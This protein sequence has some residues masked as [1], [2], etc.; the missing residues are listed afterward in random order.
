M[1]SIEQSVQLD[2]VGEHEYSA[3]LTPDWALWS[4]AGGFLTSLMMNA[5]G[6][7]TDFPQPI[8]FGCQF[9]RR[10][11]FNTVTLRVQSLR[12]GRRTEALRVDMFQAK[13]LI[14]TAQVWV[15][16]GA[17]DG[18]QHDDTGPQ[19]LPDPEA[20]PKYA[21]IYPDDPM[22]PFFDRFD[23]RP[24]DP[25][26]RGDETAHP[27]VLRGFY[28][29]LPAI[30]PDN[31]FVDAARAMVLIDTFSWLATYPAHPGDGPSPWIAPNLDFYYRF[32][33]ASLGDAW[34]FMENRADLAEG[35]LIAVAGDIR[36]QNG[37]LLVRGASQL[38]CLPRPV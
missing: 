7:E 36:N 27:A 22:P 26:L 21:E 29:F 11:T 12:R 35:G 2:K 24:I 8:S 38:I 4:P 5:A 19:E 6:L 15:G 30:L 34:L 20:L 1:K 14:A 10:A 13:D 25:V 3:Q 23:H 17:S 28:R 9:L 31:A 37:D 18:M 32:H 16:Q 33:R